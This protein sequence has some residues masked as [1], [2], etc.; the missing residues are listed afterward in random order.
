M[1]SEELVYVQLATRVPKELQRRL[2]LHCVTAEI[3]VMEFVTRAIQ[4]K[5]TG[6][7][8]PAPKGSRPYSRTRP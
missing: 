1:P 4:E 2:R 6:S 7:R 5:L 3:S 8:S